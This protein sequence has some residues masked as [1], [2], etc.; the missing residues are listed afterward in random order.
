MYVFLSPQEVYTKSPHRPISHF[1][2]HTREQTRILQT[3]D[4]LTPH[5]PALSL[6]LRE[7]FLVSDTSV[8][9][10]L[11]RLIIH[12]I[13]NTELT[14]S[15]A[16]RGVRNVMYSSVPCRKHVLEKNTECKYKSE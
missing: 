5:I 16:L 14:M 11:D 10:V 3:L 7:F 13:N 6:S 4:T 8:A 15:T 9:A 12:N 1:F 2:K